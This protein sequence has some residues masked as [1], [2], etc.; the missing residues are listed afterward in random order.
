MTRRPRKEWT[1]EEDRQL[2]QMHEDGALFKVIC[3]TLDRP[4]SSIIRRMRG[5]ALLPRK[6]G[7]RPTGGRYVV[8]RVCVPPET[9]AQVRLAA[10]ASG[11]T[12]SEHIRRLLRAA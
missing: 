8:V 4:S 3:S 6:R 12:I 10:A 1:R 2:R 9:M 11:R 5:L 7:L